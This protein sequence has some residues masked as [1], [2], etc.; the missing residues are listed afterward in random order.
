MT[1]LSFLL[2]VSWASAV[3]SAELLPLATASGSQMSEGPASTDMAGRN[4][5]IT[6]DMVPV[7]FRTADLRLER[8]VA[9]NIGVSV[10]GVAGASHAPPLLRSRWFNARKRIGGGLGARYYMEDFE[11]GSFIGIDVD[12]YHIEDISG[13]SSTLM[14]VVPRTGCK[15]TSKSGLTLSAELGIGGAV[16]IQEL[17]TQLPTQV[18]G[19]VVVVRTGVYAG[20]TF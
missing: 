8:Q 17:P 9:D 18:L 4:N 19:A 12:G 16:Y 7:V 2:S 6:I 11:R 10:H 15:L 3:P 20:W 5:T 1:L 14:E 13:V